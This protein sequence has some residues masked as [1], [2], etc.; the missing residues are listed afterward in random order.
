MGEPK[1]SKLPKTTVPGRPVAELGCKEGGS[2]L[3]HVFFTLLQMP[4]HKERE[5]GSCSIHKEEKLRKY[6]P[7]G[8]R[9][10]LKGHFESLR[11][12]IH[13]LGMC[14]NWES[15]WRPLSSWDNAQTTEPHQP[16]L[17]SFL[18]MSLSFMTLSTA[19]VNFSLKI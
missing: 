3:R 10:S 6:L 14:L 15:N 17:E 2:S 18:K 11:D 12:S 5:M 7:K 1:Q 9:F 8:P 19:T 4:L 13:S 16:E